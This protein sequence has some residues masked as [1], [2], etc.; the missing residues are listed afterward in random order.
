MPDPPNPE[1]LSLSNK[2]P[3]QQ[4]LDRAKTILQSWPNLTRS[5][6]VK[7]IVQELRIDRSTAY[8]YLRDI[9]RSLHAKNTT[10]SD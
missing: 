4:R 2:T 6:V 10:D 1:P 3:K 9:A 5:E 8:A 7:L